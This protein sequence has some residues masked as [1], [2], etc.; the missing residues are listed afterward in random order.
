M[1]D[2]DLIL[3]I[4]F[5]HLKYGKIANVKLICF[6][7]LTLFLLST[8]CTY[9]CFIFNILIKSSMGTNN[10]WYDDFLEEF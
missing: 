8:S 9:T 3:V 6:M 7:N 5:V 4:D 1:A 2:I 10:S